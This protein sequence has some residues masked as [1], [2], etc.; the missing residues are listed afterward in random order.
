MIAAY[1]AEKG[2]LDQ[3]FQ[4]DAEE[5]VAEVFA[6]YSLD[7]NR[8]AKKFPKAVAVFDKELKRLK[9]LEKPEEVNLVDCQQLDRASV[10]VSKSAFPEF[11]S[12]SN[13]LLTLGARFRCSLPPPQ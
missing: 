5:F 1:A 11:K 6:R 2:Q 13:S 12:T 8:A 10:M 9:I 4:N 7:R 3:Y